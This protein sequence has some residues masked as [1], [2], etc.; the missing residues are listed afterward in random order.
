M[1]RE[2]ERKKME[3]QTKDFNSYWPCL[4]QNQTAIENAVLDSD[5]DAIQKVFLT[6]NV[7][8]NHWKRAME[9]IT[10]CDMQPWG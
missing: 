7:P 5:F 8:K 6:C 2:T 9:Q 3:N 1:T 4:L 10:R